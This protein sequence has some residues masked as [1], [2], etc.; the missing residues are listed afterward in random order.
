V[1]D[2]QAVVLIPV[3]A[4]QQGPLEAAHDLALLGLGDV[5]LLERQHAGRVP[6]GVVAG[7][8][9]RL[10][11]VRVATQQFGTLAASIPAQ[12]ITHRP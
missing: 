4:R 9:Q 3:E 2:P 11:L 6:L 7:V 12:Q 8:D 10:G 5:R 1:L